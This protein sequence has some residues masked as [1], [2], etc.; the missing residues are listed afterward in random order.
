MRITAGILT[1]LVFAIAVQA[2]SP[3]PQTEPR[4]RNLTI[5]SNEL[6]VTDRLR[7]AHSLQGVT[8]EPN[9]VQERVRMKLVDQG[10]YYAQVDAPELSEMRQAETSLVQAADGVD[11]SV[12]VLL[13]A[14]YRL[15]VIEFK[16]AT[17]FPPDRL[18]GQ[19]P[20]E[21]GSLFNATSLSYGLV[22]LK[23][24]Y[25][26]KGHINFGAI[27][28]STID[29]KRHVVDLTIDIDEGKAYVFGRLILDGIEP[30]AGDGNALVSSWATLQGKAYNPDLLKDWLASNWPSGKE[31]LSHMHAMPEESP[32]QVNFRLEFP[33]RSVSLP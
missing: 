27:P 5:I 33:S 1:P 16:H 25:Q 29:E 18:R 7:I 28:T 4:I 23:T 3:A 21:T 24:L 32:Q 11:V 30:H 15:G 20:A 10:F 9:E 6:P 2:Q 14:Q 31:G 19:F 26:A 13:G 22:R 17:L 8:Y 12:K